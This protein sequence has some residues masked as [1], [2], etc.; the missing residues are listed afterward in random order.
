M[1]I[2]NKQLIV[3]DFIKKYIAEKGYSPTVREICTGL[4]LKSPA[5][6][7]DHIKK[8]ELAGLIA[9]DSKKSRTIELLVENEYL[10]DDTNVVMLPLYNE[11]EI[12]LEFIPIPKFITSNYNKKNL[13]VYKENNDYY[14]VN[15]NLKP[16]TGSL[17]LCKGEKTFL[18][19]DY[20]DKQILGTVISQI[21][22]FI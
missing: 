8:L 6:I 21:K 16:F 20:N 4:A 10:N 18:T 2:T 12:N 3:L 19:S 7:H 17:T 22:M 9:T 15:K 1:K 5:T 14:I 11:T 13:F